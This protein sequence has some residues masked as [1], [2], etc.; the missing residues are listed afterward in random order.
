MN[1]P[2]QV[3]I[4]GGIGSGKSLICKVFAAL[5][6]PVYDADSRAKDIMTTDGILVSQI[7]EEF[8]NLAYAKDGS[9]NRSYLSEQIFQHPQKRDK[10]NALVHP[11]VAID[12]DRWIDEQKGNR[13]V[14]REAALMF[15]S[16]SYKKLDASIVVTA[17]EW[18][19]IKRVLQ[20]DPQRS[21][22]A[23]RKIIKAQMPEEESRKR[24]NYIIENDETQLILPQII[25]LH[26]HFST[27][28]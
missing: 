22:E 8:G 20:R 7:K 15:E 13:Y 24:A 2:F 27:H 5:G 3:G 18:L 1:K 19:R 9:L 12:T 23:V 10:L 6:V 11:R 28:Q 21:E 4:T 25:K 14:I 26:H 16:G 17:P